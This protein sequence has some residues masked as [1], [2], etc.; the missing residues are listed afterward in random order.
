MPDLE[1]EREPLAK[2]GA[3]PLEGSGLEDEKDDGEFA[4]TVVD[5]TE[6]HEQ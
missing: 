2:N 4:S 5:E 1:D 6:G 3:E